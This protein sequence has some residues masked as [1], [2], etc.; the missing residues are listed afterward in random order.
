MKTSYL[1]VDNFKKYSISM[2]Q[3][4]SLRDDQVIIVSGYTVSQLTI[5][6]NIDG[7]CVQYQFAPGLPN[8]LESVRLNIGFSMARKH[9]RSVHGHVITK[10]SGIITYPW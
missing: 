7:I 5:D 2:G 10:F 1:S 6:H 8:W 4:L 3:Y 9:G